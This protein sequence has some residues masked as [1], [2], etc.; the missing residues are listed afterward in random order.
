MKL[1]KIIV[2]LVAG[3]V[4]LCVLLVGFTAISYAFDSQTLSE[5]SQG[6]FILAWETC[7][8]SLWPSSA[9][10]SAVFPTTLSPLSIGDKWND[11][12]I[13]FGV[14]IAGGIQWTL[15]LTAAWRIQRQRTNAKKGNTA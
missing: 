14:L 15:L 3:W 1:L 2:C 7:F 10:V 13:L 12:Y 8:Y 11:I 4:V 9:L 6:L 5:R